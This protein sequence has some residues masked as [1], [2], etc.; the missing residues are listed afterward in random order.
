MKNFFILLLLL[1]AFACNSKQSSSV[2]SSSVAV[3]DPHSLANPSEAIVKHLDLDIT[4]D[5]TTKQI[6]G[7]AAWSIENITGAD[8]IVFDTKD[9]SISKVTIGDNEQ[10][11]NF[12]IGKADDIFGAPLQVS[13]GPDTK[14]VIIYYTTSSNA[15]ALQWLTPQQ[16]A[17]KQQPFLFTQSQP[18]LARSWVPCQDGPAVRFTYNA[19]VKVPSQLM[20]VMSAEN[21]QTKPA[22]GVYHFRQ[23][24]PIPSYLMAL[25]VGDL[26]FKAIDNRTGIYAEPSM[27]NKSVWEFADMGKMVNAAEKLYGPYEWGRYD[28]LV[29][30]P[31]FPYG[32]M[33][34]PNLTFAT[35]TV[36]AGDRSLVSLIAHELAHSW[37]GNLVTN[38]TWD[39]MWLNE[40]FT[41]YF[42]RRLVEELYGKEEAKMQEVIER[43]GLE[44]ELAEADS[45]TDTRLKTQLAGHDPDL[46]GNSVPYEKGYAFLRLIEET[47][48][49]DKFDPFLKNYFSQNK[50]QSKTTEQ[51]LA[52]LNDSF[53]DDPS[54]KK[55][56]TDEWVNKP[57]LPASA[58]PATSANFNAIDTL[59]SNWTSSKSVIG[60]S[61]KIV[62]TNEK[63]YFIHHLPA[64]I[65]AGD[66]KALDSEFH[67]TTSGNAEVQ[68]A[69]YTIAIKHHYTPANPNIEQ[70]LTTVGR[71]KFLLPLYK[72]LIKTAEGKQW[73][74]EIYE[75][76]RGN[77]HPVAVNTFD[78]LLK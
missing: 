61:K 22:D 67:F 45:T 42:E 73:A 76:A 33:E 66:M 19:T 68:T 74:K 35:P 1:S 58:L 44:K 56:N 40:G 53:K 32:G 20:A 27:L 39:D 15:A 78:A 47:V 18:I 13:I 5:F 31:S 9:L 21:V 54:F 10:P 48:G 46:A 28:V 51:F 2:N 64:T 43:Q 16:T 69:W 4:V 55:I 14:K 30:P 8:K 26:A 11:V 7:K 65:T 23:T 52:E 37:S 41:T 38:A 29:L 17:G 63:L 36:I 59:I 75:K 50:F 71:R 77:Y 6:N 24:H 72:E 62:S 3:K 57:G 60:L 12:G 25:A 70:F 49:R 34:N